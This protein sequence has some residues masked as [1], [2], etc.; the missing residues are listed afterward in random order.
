MI[1]QIPHYIG[2]LGI[3][4]TPILHKWDDQKPREHYLGNDAKLMHQ[5]EKIATRGQIALSAG[6]AEWIAWRLG[7]HS[8]DETLFQVIQAVWAS[9]VDWRYVGNL[10]THR[11]KMKW[12]DW[13]GPVR[14]PLC[15]TYHI[16]QT[17]C[18]D[19]P[20]GMAIEP[21]MVPLS[22][23]AIYLLVDS[24]AFKAWRRSVLER[25]AKDH[26]PTKKSPDGVPVPREAI[27]PEFPYKPEMAGELVAKFLAT[28]DFKA[29]PYL[30]TPEEMK[31][32]GFSGTP[33]KL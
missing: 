27:D 25:L 12:E 2:R 28:L 19:A 1:L 29:N 15:A 16:L 8:R 32:A 26:P 14:G 20:R 18:F 11:Q 17:I 9:G 23:L 13:T 4:D 30:Q 24:K 10:K 3:A 6:M 33:Y 7:K 5:F 31:N 22:N 21:W